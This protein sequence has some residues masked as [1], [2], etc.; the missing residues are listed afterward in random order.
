M[1][2]EIW[3]EVDVEW[4]LSRLALTQSLAKLSLSFLSFNSTAIAFLNLPKT[5]PP[6]AAELSVKR[7]YTAV[8]SRNSKR[9]CLNSRSE[10]R[11]LSAL[12]REL[13]DRK[14]CIPY[15]LEVH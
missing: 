12:P 4:N 1:A 3:I 2:D 6:R 15:Q 11:L 10:S 9:F 5:T 14:S 8:L 7:H 13:P